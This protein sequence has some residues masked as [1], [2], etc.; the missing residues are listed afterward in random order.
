M[1]YIYQVNSKNK[2]E[3]RLYKFSDPNQANV[4]LDSL[5]SVKC[6]DFHYELREED[7]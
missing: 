5:N 1:F 4:K 3:Y 7:K 6:D 2:K